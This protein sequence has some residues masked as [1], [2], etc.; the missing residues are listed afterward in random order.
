M[1]WPTNCVWAS[2]PRTSWTRKWSL[3]CIL[4]KS[5]VRS[6]TV[7]SVMRPATFPG[8]SAGVSPITW[9]SNIS[10]ATRLYQPFAFH[11]SL[12]FRWDGLPGCLAMAQSRTEK[13]AV[14]NASEA[15][16]FLAAN[17]ATFGPGNGGGPKPRRALER[18]EHVHGPVL[19]LVPQL[20]QGLLDHPTAEYAD[21]VLWVRVTVQAGV[22][23]VRTRATLGGRS[24]PCEEPLRNRG[25]LRGERVPR[26]EAECRRGVATDELTP[27][28]MRHVGERAAQ[29][30]NVA[31]GRELDLALTGHALRFPLEIDEHQLPFLRPEDLSQV[32]V[33]VR[34][35]LRGA[36]G[37][38]DAVEHALDPLAGLEHHAPRGRRA[39]GRRPVR[40]LRDRRQIEAR[41]LEVRDRAD[42]TADQLRAPL[43]REPQEQVDR[44]EEL[45]RDPERDAVVPLTEREL[46]EVP[47]HVRKP[48]L[49]Q[50]RDE[51]R[52]PVVHVRQ[53]VRLEQNLA[54]L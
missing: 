22:L 2:E 8:S 33:R 49:V 7:T 51:V 42:L 47:R 41:A 18:D 48:L 50:A 37:R 25:L 38:L 29:R 10:G 54:S 30:R 17:F 24:L 13:G 28:I 44:L 26:Q 27:C 43:P 32:K 4:L 40:V 21:R 19:Q 45:Y 1:S 46:P 15:A 31:E 34:D 14:Y 36:H 11:L 20:V 53:L 3:M 35:A 16:T 6:C 23:Q 9:R 12:T 52:L 39:H 5:P